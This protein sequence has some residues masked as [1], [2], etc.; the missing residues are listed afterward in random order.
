MW[1]GATERDACG[2]SQHL[3]LTV[4]SFSSSIDFRSEIVSGRAVRAGYQLLCQHEATLAAGA[5]VAGLSVRE[6][7]RRGWSVSLSFSLTPTVSHSPARPHQVYLARF[8]SDGSLGALWQAAVDTQVEAN[9]VRTKK[10][11]TPHSWR[12]RLPAREHLF[13]TRPS[14]GPFPPPLSLPRPA[15]AR[16]LPPPPPCRE[17]ESRETCEHHKR[18]R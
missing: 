3:F 14:C 1:A 9:L 2:G 8:A 6:K 11:K 12:V 17:R 4:S 5:V 15:N 10:E 16:T 18:N 13:F 7:R